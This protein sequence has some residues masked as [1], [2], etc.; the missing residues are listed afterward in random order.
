MEKDWDD[1]TEAEV[2]DLWKGMYQDEHAARNRLIVESH[3]IGTAYT[4]IV[5][6]NKKYM[7]YIAILEK[8]IVNTYSLTLGGVEK[9]QEFF[10]RA[11]E[12]AGLGGKDEDDI[13][14]CL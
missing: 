1:M 6:Q 11:K 12:Q 5:E 10:Y 4:L 14:D 13:G 7:N 3:D 9:V 2:I 8:F